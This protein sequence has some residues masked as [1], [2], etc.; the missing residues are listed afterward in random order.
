[1]S[2]QKIMQTYYSNISEITDIC[3]DIYY[4]AS[5][6]YAKDPMI[7]VYLITKGMVPELGFI[8]PLIQVSI[9]GKD[10]D[11][12][13]AIADLVIKHSKYQKLVVGDY[14]VVSVYRSDKI[15]RDNTWWHIPV[16]LELKYMEV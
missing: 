11:T 8:R 14:F 16:E 15:F 1:M 12:V 3:S 2:P 4:D 5:P 10:N 6:T 7:V 9:Y 13:Q